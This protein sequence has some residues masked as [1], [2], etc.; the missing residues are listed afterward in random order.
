[1]FAPTEGFEDMRTPQL[2]FS[3]IAAS[4]G[5]L[6]GAGIG[7]G[8]A[9]AAPVACPELPQ[10]VIDDAVRT[11][12]P[13]FPGVAWQVGAMGGS[14]DCT[15]NWVRLDTPQGTASSPV[16]ILSFDHRKFAGTPTK[17]ANAYTSVVGSAG[18][19]QITVRFAWLEPSD[20]NAAPSG[21]ADVRF[22]TM[23]QSP[24]RPLDPIPAPV[25]D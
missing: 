25:A 10:N 13:P 21:R 9:A 19:G 17:R 8:P 4:V 2:A 12:A 3:V 22:Q 11:V 23:P 20:P 5:A 15:L 14:V 16:Q 7:A 24:P 6:A 1:M 18:P